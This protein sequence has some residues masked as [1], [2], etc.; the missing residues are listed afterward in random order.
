[1]HIYIDWECRFAESFSLGVPTA[2]HP[3]AACK[4]FAYATFVSVED[5]TAALAALNGLDIGE[6]TLKAVYARDHGGAHNPPPL[7]RRRVTRY[8]PGAREVVA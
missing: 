7:P 6:G 3:C 2:A 8:P 4:G 5:A 1:M